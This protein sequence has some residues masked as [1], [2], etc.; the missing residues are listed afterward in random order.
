M[1]DVVQHRP[2]AESRRRT[3]QM[4]LSRSSGNVIDN[5]LNDANVGI[6]EDELIGRLLEYVDFFEVFRPRKHALCLRQRRRGADIIKQKHF[7][8][9]ATLTLTSNSVSAAVTMIISSDGFNLANSWA[10]HTPLIPPPITIFDIVSYEERSPDC[11]Q[12]CLDVHRIIY[13]ALLFDFFYFVAANGCVLYEQRRRP[14]AQ[15]RPLREVR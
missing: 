9:H 10:Q 6:G 1:A 4:H 14:K 2:W 8:P 13:T 12:L 3:F 11:P 7:R 15:R 5:V